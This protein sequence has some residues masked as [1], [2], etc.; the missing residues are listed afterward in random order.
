[1][2]IVEVNGRVLRGPD[3]TYYVGDG[4]TYT[5][6]VVSGLED[7]STVD[8]AKTISSASQVE[9]YVNGTKKDLNTH[10]TVDVGNNNV[11]FNTANVP[12]STDVICISTLVDHQYF[13]EGTD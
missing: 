11:E 7:D 2:T 6:G 10:Y 13:N 9:V 1:M 8:P 4:S 5:Y 3:N 12:T